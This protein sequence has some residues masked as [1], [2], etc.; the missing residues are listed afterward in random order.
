MERKIQ[1]RVNWLIFLG[2]LG[3]T[4]LILRIWGSMHN[5]QGSR[6]SDP[7]GGSLTAK[8]DRALSTALY[9]KDQPQPTH[10]QWKQQ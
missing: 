2:I 7:L 5:I 1:F 6:C 3:E 10:N 9:N 4:E 8:L